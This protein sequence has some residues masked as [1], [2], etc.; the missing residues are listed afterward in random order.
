M[1][2]ASEDCTV[3]AEWRALRQTTRMT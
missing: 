3:S 2:F 1:N